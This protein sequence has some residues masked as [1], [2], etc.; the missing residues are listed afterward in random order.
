MSGAVASIYWI[1]EP[2]RLVRPELVPTRIA[3]SS[4]LAA[5][6]TK[7]LHYSLEL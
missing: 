4:F 1:L 2:L 6:F 5:L 3:T 7:T